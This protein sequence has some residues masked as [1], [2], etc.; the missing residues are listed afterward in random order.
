MFTIVILELEAYVAKSTNTVIAFSLILF[1]ACLPQELY[2]WSIR[3]SAPL[4]VVRIQAS[5]LQS[6][7]LLAGAMFRLMHASLLKSRESLVLVDGYK[8]FARLTIA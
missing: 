3:L 2:V 7:T 8:T 5:I 1:G 4:P 6:V